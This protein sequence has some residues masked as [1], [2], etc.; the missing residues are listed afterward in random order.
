MQRITI[1]PK[2][3]FSRPLLISTLFLIIAS[4]PAFGQ[5]AESI[6]ALRQIGKAF[7]QIA[8]KTSPAVV[9]VKAEQVVTGE[10][11]GRQELPFS[12][13]FFDDEFFEQFFRRD[14]RRQ[15]PSQ[16]KSVRPVQGSGFI[17]SADGFI[18]TN[19]HVVQ[20]AEKI[21]VRLGDEREFNA[22]VIGTDPESEVAVIKI[23]ANDLSFLQFADSD[24][25]EVGEWVLAI[26][27]PFGL[28]HTVTAGIVSAKGRSD[29]GLAMYEDYI[30]TDAAINPGNSGGPLLNLDGK[31][32]GIN[33]AIYGAAGNIGIGFAIPINMAKSVYEQI[34]DGGTVVRGFLGV[35][36][37]DLTEAMADYFGLEGTKGVILNEVTEDSA[38]DKAGLKQGDILI[39][40]DGR[41][42]EK[43]DKFRKDVAM[44][45]PGTKVDAV[46]LRAGK[47]KT[48][49]V[50]LSERP[51]PEKIATAKPEILEQLGIVVEN[52]TPELARQL[53]YQGLGGVVVTQSAPGSLA[54]LAGIK[55]GTL[56][57]EV[58]QLAVKDTKEFHKA[59]KK[60]AE[61]KS[62]LLLVRDKNFSRYV[63]IELPK[64]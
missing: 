20:N 64:E 61:K 27:N 30:Q 51:A 5:D 62:I 44:L 49:T 6:K 52:L 48:L 23:D 32:V 4:V 55:A 13:P 53:G 29:V 39:E 31:V 45:K 18:L 10:F 2:K 59:I 38:A 22:K 12:D 33:T 24:S 25:I 46:V 17:I 28:S 15:Q 63:A 3:N 42:V 37:S 8:E 57:T 9:W 11:G 43:A 54:A 56:I 58:N 60:A 14:F 47:R 7:A 26:G 41:A 16:R 40:F 1:R 36:P 50:E 19:N 21:T 34:V 35:V